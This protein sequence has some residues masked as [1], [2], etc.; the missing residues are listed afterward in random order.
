MIV[1]FFKFIKILVYMYVGLFGSFLGQ[2]VAHISTDII[3]TH[4]YASCYSFK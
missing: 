4:M 2:F 1:M 3:P